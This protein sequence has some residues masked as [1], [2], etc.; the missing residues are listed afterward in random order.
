MVPKKADFMDFN[1]LRDES[2]RMYCIYFDGEPSDDYPRKVLYPYA[3]LAPAW[4]DAE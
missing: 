1:E 2:G 4:S 3:L